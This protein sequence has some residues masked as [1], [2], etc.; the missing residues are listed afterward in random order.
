M[1]NFRI[2]FKFSYWH[3]QNMIFQ[4]YI[5]SYE[6]SALGFMQFYLIIILKTHQIS[7]NHWKA[8]T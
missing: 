7:A 5:T 1:Q 2:F 3:F 4:H 6:M 8:R